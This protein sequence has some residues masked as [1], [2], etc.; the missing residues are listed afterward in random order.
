MHLKINFA[1]SSVGILPETYISSFSFVEDID[2]LYTG[3]KII[4]R[5]LAQNIYNQLKI[6]ANVEVTFYGSVDNDSYK[7]YMRILE[8]KKVASSEDLVNVVDVTLISNWYFETSLETKSYRG[9]V[10][11][12]IQKIYETKFKELKLNSNIIATEDPSRIRYQ[13]SETS[14]NF[15]KHLLLK[16]YSQNSPLYLYT[17][18]RNTLN[19]RSLSDFLSSNC[20]YSYVPDDVQTTGEY[21]SISAQQENTS[22]IRL[23]NYKEKFT[24]QD[25]SSQHTSYFTT[26]AFASSTTQAPYVTLR[27]AEFNN[28]QVSLTSPKTINYKDWSYTPQDALALSIKEYYSKSLGAFAVAGSIDG[29]CLNEARLGSLIK[30]ILPSRSLEKETLNNRGYV[31]NHIE[32][33]CKNN[34]EGVNFTA[35]LAKY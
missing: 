16:G 12:I 13:I 27:N 17:D 25:T 5:D 7:N 2:K 30:I 22:L 20:N 9:S 28:N 23:R 21:S 6:G 35:F 10:G 33:V 29:L 26:S 11:T 8:V 4:I 34:A 18:S 1:D 24:T 31:I 15:M 3:A 19:L 32:R 14:Q